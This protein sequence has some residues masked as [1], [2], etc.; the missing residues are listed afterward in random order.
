[1]SQAVETAQGWDEWVKFMVETH[2]Y[3]DWDVRIRKQFEFLRKFLEQLPPGGNV[4]DVGA[5]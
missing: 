4:L 2:E 1:M 5:G 3:M